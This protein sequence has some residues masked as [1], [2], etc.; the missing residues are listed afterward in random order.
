MDASMDILI[1]SARLNVCLAA[2]LVITKSFAQMQNAKLTCL[3]EKEIGNVNVIKPFALE[4]RTPF[5]KNAPILGIQ[6]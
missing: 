6:N 3:V 4:E 1:T 2:N 5:V